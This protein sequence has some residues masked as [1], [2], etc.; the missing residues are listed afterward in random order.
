MTGFFH[1]NFQ[2][3]WIQLARPYVEIL[4]SAFRLATPLMFAALGG[5]LSE[6]SG[7]INIALEGKMLIGAFAGAAV[8][9]A[10]GSGWAGL[11]GGALAAAALGALYAFM[12][13]TCRANQI[14]AGT[15]IN[16]LAY[17]ITPFFC[18]ILY[19]ATGQS[20]PVE[21]A[22]RFLFEPVVLAVVLGIVLVAFLRFTRGGLWLTMAGDHPDALQ[23]AGI[24]VRAV[25]F[26]AVTV[27]GALAGI[28]G[29]CLSLFLASG[30]SRNMTAGRGFMALAALILGKWTPTGAL[31]AC[32]LL[33]LADAAQ[34]RIQ[35]TIADT[36]WTIPLPVVQML[37]YLA[38]LIIVAGFLGRSQPAASLGVPR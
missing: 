12:T 37:P 31:I 11:G 35:T 30:F 24:S 16:M 36:G 25:R 2:A 22:H 28:G 32:L 26:G 13:I 15:A 19:G 14:I 17:G 21:S 1:P 20:P 9:L 10:V 33:G 7:V 5:M 6:R 4:F 23:S 34:I 27:G 8:T 29:A 18:K 3:E 38:T